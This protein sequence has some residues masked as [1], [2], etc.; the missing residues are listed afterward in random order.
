VDVIQEI[1]KKHAITPGQVTLAW[2]LAQGKNI[3]P[4]PGTKKIKVRLLLIH[5]MTSMPSNV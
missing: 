4:I 5:K 2:L 1:G 3:I